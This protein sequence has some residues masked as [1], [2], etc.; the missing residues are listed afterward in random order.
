MMTDLGPY[1]EPPEPYERRNPLER[2]A[3]LPEKTRIWLER[4]PDYTMTWLKNLRE[5]DIAEYEAARVF[6]RTAKVV[7][8]VNAWIVGTVLG[9][10]F[11]GLAFGEGILKVIAWTRGM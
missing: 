4:L 5:E 8:R 6:Y 10:F 2:Y 11:G 1:V 3:H 7:G 9:L